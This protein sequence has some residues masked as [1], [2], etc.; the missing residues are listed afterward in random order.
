MAAVVVGAA[1]VA[2]VASAA[3]VVVVVAPVLAVAVV[4]LVAVAATERDGSPSSSD[5]VPP[6]PSL[7]FVFHPVRGRKVRGR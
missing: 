2:A 5:P 3:V 4:D 7:R 6:G 1:P